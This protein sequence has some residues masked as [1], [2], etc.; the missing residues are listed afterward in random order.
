LAINLK[1][2]DASFKAGPYWSAQTRPLWKTDGELQTTQLIAPW[3]IKFK[4]NDC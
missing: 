3:K 4:S 1:Y 2:F